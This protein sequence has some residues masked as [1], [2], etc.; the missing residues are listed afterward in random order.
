[1]LNLQAAQLYPTTATTFA[2]DDVPAIGAGGTLAPT[3]ITISRAPGAST[4]PAVPLS[5]GGNLTID[6]TQINQDGVVRAPLGQI[7]LGEP[8]NAQGAVISAATVT[9]GSGSV[10]SVSADGL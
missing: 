2:I 5:A 4:T 8:L 3:V 9:L 6:A 10:T 7:T 1:V